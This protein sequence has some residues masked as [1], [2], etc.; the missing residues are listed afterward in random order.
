MRKRVMAMAVLLLCMVGILAGAGNG[1]V[2]ADTKPEEK[3]FSGDVKLLKQENSNYVMQVT[4][5]N[6]G[7]DFSGTVQV[8]FANTERDNCA[9]N[10]E[11]SLPS[12]GEKQFTLTIPQRA[13][14]LS[15][16]CAL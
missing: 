8:V 14:T 15:A 6:T 4:V 7:E 11:L 9:Y 5:G 16:V 3:V 2:Y 13:Q 12:Q 10:T 1:V